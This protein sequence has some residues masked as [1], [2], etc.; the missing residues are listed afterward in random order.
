MLITVVIT[1][2]QHYYLIILYQGDLTCC[3]VA[4][5]RERESEEVS[6]VVGSSLTQV[7]V[8]WNFLFVSVNI[9]SVELDQYRVF[10]V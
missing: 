10:S 6:C 2:L 1:L 7:R 8:R 9:I 4:M 3:V 5:M